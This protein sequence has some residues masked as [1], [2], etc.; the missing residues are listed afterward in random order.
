MSV[1]PCTPSTPVLGI[2]QFDVA[3]FLAVYP[4]FAG[5]ATGSP[6][7]SPIL[8]NN[9]AVA[10][11]LLNNTCG[12]R[13]QDANVRQLFLYLL[14]AHLTFI[15]NGTNDN[16]GNVQPPLGIV[17]RIN[18]ASQGD[19]SV[20]SEFATAAPTAS[21]QAYYT[22]TK[23]GAQYW[24]LTA[25]YRTFVYVPAPVG[26]GPNATPYGGPYSGVPGL[27]GCGCG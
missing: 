6:P 3:E 19:V 12:S 7:V 20:A 26:C 18:N 5:F 10:T 17:G 15:S 23:Y 9:F 27:P 14:V 1:V 2:V 4:E 8:S 22:Q 16:A 24:Q 11:Q 21:G 13:V 25:R